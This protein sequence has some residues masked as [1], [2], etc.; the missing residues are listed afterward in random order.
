MSIS[1]PSE[2]ELPLYSQACG[3]LLLLPEVPCLLIRWHGFANSR[4]LRRLLDKGLE[5]YQQHRAQYPTLGW[6]SDTR[7]FGAMLPA[8]Q[9]WAAT[10]WNRRAHAAG[11]RHL[12][13][14]GPENVFGQIAIQQYSRN[15]TH[16][17]YRLSVSYYASLSQACCF[18]PQLPQP[19][20]YGQA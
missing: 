12:G 17:A 9:H 19:A 13:F 8:D 16:G 4:N 10:D 20:G 3:E 1:S 18:L 15:A 6:L 2:P 14:L 11:I 5:L 7:Q